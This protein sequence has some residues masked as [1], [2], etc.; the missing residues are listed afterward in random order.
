M[1][2]FLSDKN[3]RLRQNKILV[4]CHLHEVVSQKYAAQIDYKP[5]LSHANL[6]Q[7]QSAIQ[8]IKPNVIIFNTERVT[9]EKMR[10]LRD[11]LPGKQLAV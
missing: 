10:V 3:V 5:Y 11:Y 7:W 1:T 4:I 2:R 8:Q 9:R 6:L